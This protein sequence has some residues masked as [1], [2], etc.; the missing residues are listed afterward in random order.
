MSTTIDLLFDYPGDFAIADRMREELGL[1]LFESKST[2]GEK[3]FVF[4]LVSISF[5]LTK[6]RRT[7]RAPNGSILHFNYAIETH[8][9]CEEEQLRVIVIAL[10][11]DSI[12]RLLLVENILLVYDNQLPMGYF[13]RTQDG[14]VWDAENEKILNLFEYPHFLLARIKD[15]AWRKRPWEEQGPGVILD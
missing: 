14:E 8:L 3:Y 4:D 12:E 9:R 2:T 13:E 15:E 1:N 11:I 5:F 10:L 6:K 7:Y